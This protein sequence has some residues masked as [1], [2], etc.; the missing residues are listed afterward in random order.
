MRYMHR[1][2]TLLLLSAFL[3]CICPPHA[4]DAAPTRYGI[5]A[6]IEPTPV[7]SGPA[8]DSRVLTTIKTGELFLVIST[9]GDWCNV[10]ALDNTI[11]YTPKSKVSI[12][13]RDGRGIGIIADP[14]NYATIFAG[15]S[16][17]HKALTKIQEGVEFII[18]GKSDWFRVLTKNKVEGYIQ[19]GQ[20]VEIWP[21]R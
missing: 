15:P 5:A 16:G 11:G 20:V 21:Y 12:R 9:E 19:A 4:A 1:Y 18:I 8:K 6:A 10:F 7:L 17:N 13:W 3:F 14:S 2:T